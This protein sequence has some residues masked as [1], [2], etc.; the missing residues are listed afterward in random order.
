M[1]FEDVMQ[2]LTVDQFRIVS[3]MLLSLKKENDILRTILKVTLDLSS[4]ILEEA[5]RVQEENTRLKE[6]LKWVRFVDE[7]PEEGQKIEVCTRCRSGFSATIDVVV[8]L[9]GDDNCFDL[10]HDYWRPVNLPQEV[11]E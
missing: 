6:Q 4:T 3:E 11:E 8:A 5:V 9:P 1:D 2:K 10:F 7:L